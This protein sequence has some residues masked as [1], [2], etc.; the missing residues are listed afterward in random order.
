MS[1]YIVNID[2]P[3]GIVRIHRRPAS[4]IRCTPQAKHPP[5]GHWEECDSLTAANAIAR[6]ENCRAEPCQICNPR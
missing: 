1:N 5:D 2:R 6:R 3:T 4:D